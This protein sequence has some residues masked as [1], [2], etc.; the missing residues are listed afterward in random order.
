MEPDPFIPSLDVD[1]EIQMFFKVDSAVVRFHARISNVDVRIC[2]EYAILR[3]RG[4]ISQRLCLSVKGKDSF[5][6]QPAA[7]FIGTING[8]ERGSR[9][10]EN[11]RG[12]DIIRD[13]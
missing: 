1:P 10:A 4:I 8:Y 2:L 5:L 11:S 9:V 12:C 13:C 7:H 6:H 3:Q